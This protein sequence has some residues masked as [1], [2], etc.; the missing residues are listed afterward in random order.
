MPHAIVKLWRG[1]SE[2]Q[3][4]DLS[5]AIVCGVTKILSYGEELVS[6]DFEGVSPSK[7]SARVYQPDIKGKWHTLRETAGVR[8]RSEIRR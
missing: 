7:W 8:F 6:V 4:R 5:D 3:K 1:K 2:A